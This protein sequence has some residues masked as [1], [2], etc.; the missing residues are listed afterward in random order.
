MN[1]IK[2]NLALV[3]TMI[4]EACLRVGRPMEEIV[5]IAV[6]KGHD[7]SCIEQAYEAGHRDFGENYAQEMLMKIKLAQ[8]K[9]LAITWHFLGAIQSNKLKIIAQA[10][11]IHSIASLAQATLLNDMIN[12]KKRVLLEVN[13]NNHPKRHGCSTNNLI[14]LALAVSQLKN[15]E[16]EGLMCI[17]P[18]DS[19]SPPNYWFAKMADLRTELYN[20]KGFVNLT[21]SM[22][23]SNDF[24]LA[25]PLGANYL[26]I[27]TKIFGA[28]I[29]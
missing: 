7:F 6:S 14:T 27:G 2:A 25:I 5:L 17:A 4:K 26:R 20:S 13:L 1:T 19:S 29:I 3:N 9:N 11:L 22:G 12:I 16:L 21:L 10:N 23:M 8:Q 18:N 24:L 15:L 28:Q